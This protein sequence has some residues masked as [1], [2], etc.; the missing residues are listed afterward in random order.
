MG[1]VQGKAAVFASTVI[2][3]GFCF[4][5]EVSAAT[6][7]PKPTI[8]A[9]GQR[10]PDLPAEQLTN[11]LIAERL[12]VTVERLEN[13]E[14]MRN[15]SID[16]V[17]NMPSAML[18]R[19]FRKAE[20]P[21][22]D[23]PGEWAAF[24]AMQQSV[25]GV[26]KP[27]GLFQ[28]YMQR[29][30]ILQAQ[31]QK[32]RTTAVMPVAG[33]ASG[34]WQ[35]IGPGNIGGR[36]RSIA[37]NPSLTST[38]F[39]GGVSGGIW[40]STNSGGS[41]APVNDFMGNLAISSIVFDPLNSNIL[42][43]GTGEGFFNADAVRGFGVFKS[44]DGGVSWNLLS[45]TNPTSA[46]ADWYYVN[47]VAVNGSLVLAA[48]RGGV[49][50][51]SDSGATWTKTYTP[52]Y[53]GALDLKI[54]PNNANNAVVGDRQG[55]VAYTAN[56]GLN[57][58]T[59]TL[60]AISGF[61]GR[62]ELA[63]A[64]SAS[65]TVY[66]SEDINN[67]AVYKST[68][69]GASWSLLST[70]AHVGGQGW[71][72][73]AIWVDPTNAN[74]LIVGGLDLKRSTDGGV[75]FA[76]ISTWYYSPASPHADHHVIVSDPNYNGTSNR[77]IYFGNDGG[78][79]AAADI[80][81]VNS[82]SS[83]NGWTNLNNGLAITQFYS[84]A[85]RSTAG[86][87]IIGGTQD[88]GS[89]VYTG[90]SNWST[91]FGGDGG[92]SAV[93][94]LDGNYFYGE[95]VYLAIHRATNGLSGSPSS[96]M[97]CSGIG[98]ANGS[99]CGG[100]GSANFIA[101]FVLDP[102]N[103]SKML[104]GGSSLWRSSN[105]K[106]GTP[107]WS[108][109]KSPIG[110]GYWYY[111]SAISVATGNSDI[112]WVGH[113]DGSVYKTTNGTSA[114]PTWTQVRSAYSS[115]VA[116]KLLIDQDNPSIV[117]VTYGGYAAGNV[118]KTTDAGVTWS[119]ISG[120]LPQ[121]PIRSFARFP[122]NANWLYA[123]TE[124]GVFASTN[125]GANWA[126]IND[127]P[128]NVDVNELFWYDNTTLVAATHGRGMFK[129]TVEMPT[130]YSLSVSKI[131]GGR[132]TSNVAGIDCGASC[133]ASYSS[134]TM[135]TLTA[136]P[137]SGSSFASWGGAC[138]GTSPTC[139]VNMN[140]AR[141]VSVT[142]AATC[143]STVDTDNDGIPDCIETAQGTNPNVKDNDVFG[144]SQLFV[145]Q[146]YRDFLLREGDAS[147]ISGWVNAINSS[148]L[149]RRQVI[150]SFFGSTEFQS[151]RAP[152]VRL[153][154]A[155]FLRIPDYAG[156]LGW[157]NNA[158]NGMTLSQISENFAQ[159]SEFLT[160]YGSLTNDQFVTLLYQNVL[161]RVPDSAGKTGWVNQLNAGSMTRGQVML[162]FSESSEN[163]T[164]SVNKVKV[165]MLYVA[166][167]RRSP[168]QSS[169]NSAVTAMNGGV[170]FLDLITGFLNSTEYRK[171]FLP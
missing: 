42:Y 65:G 140:A 23:S 139:I 109:I 48:T 63:Y 120:V 171:R 145:K 95:Y 163:V 64:K 121:V 130:N 155:F 80:N 105:V 134:G 115:R 62:V 81:L 164:K 72:D 19:S 74:H 45:S 118:L 147:G 125:G 84:G 159:S 169:F 124:V 18:A 68:N 101:P 10:C 6:A 1:F 21:K 51:S 16:A 150:D 49:Y 39:A 135:V 106:A 126:A 116:L 82:N 69:G 59:A 148:A 2:V 144:N 160:R 20:E 57:W 7:N 107:T 152:I 103:N 87:R 60:G 91:F 52:A 104:A 136:T 99:Y 122:L 75:T 46:G 15:L 35:S 123:G 83:A 90:T 167:L 70:P 31:A 113:N 157:M 40:K 137:D 32:A 13:V 8:E 79:Y 58:S 38:L 67:G 28:G 44:T 56:G 43:A 24:R 89:L 50:R 127:G 54:D 3:A 33:I 146:Q 30:A 162:A 29:E 131:G 114:T 149:T 98:D 12:G 141:S 97:I 119:D 166:L 112:I 4:T 9:P 168:D 128:A 154:F 129:T 77:K 94:S 85:G 37:V 53:I 34:Q 73:N 86:A 22:P 100:S 156:L 142:F 76:N 143:T 93:D 55:V 14:R 170:S 133:T 96:S 26:V 165:T 117:Y 11:E 47:R 158:K 111:I 102:N 36:I 88:N 27:D 108:A 138:S 153:Y 161:G 132:V 66:A 61:S 151:N 110:A 78:V 17:C 5:G 25:N 41:W 92:Y 71:Y